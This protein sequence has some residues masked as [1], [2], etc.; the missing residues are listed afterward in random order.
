MWPMRWRRGRLLTGGK[1]VE[2]AGCFFEPA[3]M[4]GVEPSARL[5]GE[6]T[7]GPLAAILPFD[8]E[9]QALAYANDTS[10]GLAAYLY[11]RDLSRS[12]RVTEGLRYGM[13]GLNTG[14]ISTEV[15]PFGVKQSGIGREGSRYGLDEYLD[16]KL[17]CTAVAPR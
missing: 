4:A 17:V 8:T 1:R 12:H 6:E 10:A 14:L 3:V 2:R 5:C 15:A 11:T 7:F 16:M 9:E 13:V